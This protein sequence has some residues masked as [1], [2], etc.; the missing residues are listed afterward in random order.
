MTH[1]L[2]PP[3]IEFCGAPATSVI[4]Q[5]GH[6]EIEFGAGLEN[7]QG[8]GR[9]LDHSALAVEELALGSLVRPP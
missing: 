9:G 1:R 3:M 4:W 5:L 8:G 7:P 2:A 6:A